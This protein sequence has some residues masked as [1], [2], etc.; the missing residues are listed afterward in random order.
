MGG[1]R[2]AQLIELE[3]H[4]AAVALAQLELA[5]KIARVAGSRRS[6]ARAAAPIIVTVMG[7]AVRPDIQA[8]NVLK[9]R[10]STPA[11]NDIDRTV[12]LAAVLRHGIS[13]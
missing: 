8:L 12:S 1:E 3:L 9:N 4:E 13:M 10:Q 6:A 2:R 7:D 5:R 11:V